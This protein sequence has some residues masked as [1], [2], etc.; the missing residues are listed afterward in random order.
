MIAP[1]M[2]AQDG[3]RAALPASGASEGWT[4]ADWARWFVFQDEVDEAARVLQPGDGML[5]GRS[6]YLNLVAA[7]ER[8][9][10][11]A[12]YDEAQGLVSVVPV[13]GQAGRKGPARAPVLTVVKKQSA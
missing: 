12:T 4:R 5:L 6:D 13:A 10:L 2:S 3:D 8:R 11:S 9:G 7:L 1:I